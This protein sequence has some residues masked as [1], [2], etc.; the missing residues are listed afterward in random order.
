MLHSLIYIQ[1][2]TLRVTKRRL[3][4]S[5]LQLSRDRT[6]SHFFSICEF[7]S[8]RICSGADSLALAKIR[9]G[10]CISN[11]HRIMSKKSTVKTLCTQ[12]I[13]ALEQLKMYLYPW[14][15]I[16]IYNFLR[17]IYRSKELTAASTSYLLISIRCVVS[18]WWGM[19]CSIPKRV[20]LYRNNNQCM[21]WIWWWGSQWHEDAGIGTQKWNK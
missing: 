13:S 2:I 6:S 4:W 5:R 15:E 8:L 21:R 1:I 14:Y 12:S 9:I 20:R 3:C 17:S 10:I 16:K 18:Y 19:A 7:V 11:Q